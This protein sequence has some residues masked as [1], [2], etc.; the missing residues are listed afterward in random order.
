M[1]SRLLLVLCCLLAAACG[2]AAE[3]ENANV[4]PG[5][6]GPV[7]AE[8]QPF[9]ADITVR[10]PHDRAVR[11]ERLDST[12]TCT[13]REIADTLILPRGTTRLHVTVDNTNRSGDRSVGVTVFLTDPDLD[14][15]EVSCRWVVRP[16]VAIDSL[17]VTQK[18]TRQRPENRGFQD[19]YRYVVHERPDEPNRL[20]KRLRLF[21]PP[22]E[23]PVGGLAILGIDYLGEI[24]AF[25]PRQ[26][27]DGS[28]LVVASAKGGE[29]AVLTEQTKSETVVIRTNHPRKPRLELLFETDLDTGAGR[30]T[31]DPMA[32][33]GP[34]M[35][36]PPV[37]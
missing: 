23:A 20:R 13:R 24:W 17:P 30:E 37:R 8:D 3:V 16:T 33:P 34:P 19:I 5:L 29:N 28:W 35:L 9:V 22:E 25:T 12:C 6:A 7:M 11:V 36:P 18:D 27:D 14:P 26:Q 21:S 15:I 10:N 1:I 2:G 4:A 31:R 32:I